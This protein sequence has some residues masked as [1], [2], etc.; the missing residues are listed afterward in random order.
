[1]N[2]CRCVRIVHIQCFGPF[3]AEPIICD[4]ET[5]FLIQ[6]I[7]NL[8]ESKQLTMRLWHLIHKGTHI[9]VAHICGTINR[10]VGNCFGVNKVIDEVGITQLSIAKTVQLGELLAIFCLHFVVLSSKVLTQ[11]NIYISHCWYSP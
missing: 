5:I 9:L 1:M 10:G 8:V 7:I 4:F 6:F 2:E 3:G 11:T